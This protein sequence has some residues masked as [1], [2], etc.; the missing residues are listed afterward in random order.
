M[1]TLTFSYHRHREHSLHGPGRQL[2][3]L[4]RAWYQRAHQRRQLAQLD[5]R[6]LEDIGVSRAQAEAEAAKPFWQD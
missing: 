2:P 1:S 3:A 6:A 5:D 4:L